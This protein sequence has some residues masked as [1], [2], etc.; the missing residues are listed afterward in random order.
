MN[1]AMMPVQGRYTSR[2][3][4]S[5]KFLDIFNSA[6]EIVSSVA[7]PEIQEVVGKKLG[8]E[9]PIDR[10]KGL[11][12]LDSFSSILV[13]KLQ[14]RVPSERKGHRLGSKFE[15]YEFFTVIKEPLL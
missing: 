14:Y 1:S 4:S 2:K 3:I 8:I 13:V 11:T 12:V 10:E 7:Y 9:I 15:D 6:S 5:D